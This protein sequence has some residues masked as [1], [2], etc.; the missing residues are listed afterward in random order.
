MNLQAFELFCMQ[1][2]SPM[3]E[4]N[5][6]TEPPD[7]AKQNLPGVEEKKCRDS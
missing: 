6:Q 1:R 4:V 7:K 2:V 3:C 5:W